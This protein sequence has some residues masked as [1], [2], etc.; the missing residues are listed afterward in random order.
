M[1]PFDNKKEKVYAGK[2][3]CALR[4]GIVLTLARAPPNVPTDPAMW[5]AGPFL[6]HY[7]RQEQWAAAGTVRIKKQPRRQWKP[8]PTLVKEMERILV[9]IGGAIYLGKVRLHRYI[10]CTL[11]VTMV[12]MGGDLQPGCLTDTAAGHDRILWNFS[13]T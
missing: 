13:T 9:P 5:F 3:Q 7:Y 8:L 6:W 11:T 2:H 10:S 12:T 1:L 4:K